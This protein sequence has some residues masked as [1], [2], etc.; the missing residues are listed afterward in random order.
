MAAKSEEVHSSGKNKKQSA[1]KADFDSLYDQIS[2]G[3]ALIK[4]NASFWTRK[5]NST[6]YMCVLCNIGVQFQKNLNVFK[7][8]IIAHVEDKYHKKRYE[9]YLAGSMNTSSANTLTTDNKCS[10]TTE[11]QTL[12]KTQPKVS[13]VAILEKMDKALT[14]LTD[15]SQED[16][17][18]N[19]YSV[20]IEMYDS[21]L[22]TLKVVKTDKQYIVSSSNGSNFYCTICNVL[23]F[24]SPN[25]KQLTYNLFVH[26]NDPNHVEKLPNFPEVKKDFDL[27]LAT[28]FK[29]LPASFKEEIHDIQIG[30]AIDF[31]KCTLCNLAV[32]DNVHRLENHLRCKGHLNRRQRRV[33]G[34][35]LY[36]DC[37]SERILYKFRKLIDELD[38][39]FVKDVKYIFVGK[40]PGY[41]VCSLCSWVVLP[42]KFYLERHI[43]SKMHKQNKSKYLKGK[44]VIFEITLEDLQELLP[45]KMRADMIFKDATCGFICKLCDTIVPPTYYDVYT[46]IKQEKLAHESG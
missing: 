40:L 43:S 29:A 18:E 3:N 46:H 36:F 1:G 6:K 41:V 2:E 28:F 19:D 13:V 7:S 16:E 37:V 5:G 25:S 4:A 24:N 34:E 17:N 12:T 45:S 20:D 11:T 15:K 22:K 30:P 35:K 38:R 33:K 39:E 8:S 9:S 23:I 27:K 44:D 42:S 26:L 32:S 14:H 21:I 31:V 10:D